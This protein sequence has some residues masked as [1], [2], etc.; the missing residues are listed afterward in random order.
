MD[1]TGIRAVC[2]R[3]HV[4]AYVVVLF[5]MG[6]ECMEWNSE[7]IRIETHSFF[8]AVAVDVKRHDYLSCGLFALIIACVFVGFG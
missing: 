8:V 6:R 2:T 1:G 7:N 4:C 3:A 5:W